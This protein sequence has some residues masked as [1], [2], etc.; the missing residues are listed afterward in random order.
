MT[1]NNPFNIFFRIEV[2]LGEHDT[3]TVKDC[4]IDEYGEDCADDAIDVRIEEE[5]THE[6]YTIR[7]KSQK[8]DIGLLRLIRS[9][10]YTSFIRP[11]CLSKPESDNPVIADGAPLFVAGWGLT[12]TSKYII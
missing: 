11:I 7:K 5:I 9:V 10:Q 12:E 3:S 4:Q 2:R 1:I 6:S 8:Y